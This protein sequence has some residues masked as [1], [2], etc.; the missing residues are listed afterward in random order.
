MSDIQNL[1]SLYKNPYARDG[2]MHRTKG[3]RDSSSSFG[4]GQDEED[5]TLDHTAKKVKKMK[6]LL[7]NGS[8]PLLKGVLPLYEVAEKSKK[9]VLFIS[10]SVLRKKLPVNKA[11]SSNIKII[12]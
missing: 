2:N 1:R 11:P 5:E 6:E 10:S 7:G 4:S 3:D 8:H 9:N 12:Q